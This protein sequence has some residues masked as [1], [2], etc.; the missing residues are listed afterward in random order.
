MTGLVPN[1]LLFDFEIPIRHRSEPP[2]LGGDLD[3]WDERSLLPDLCR[4]E[5]QRPFGRV[6][7]AWSAEG[8]YVA[9]AVSGKQRTLRCDPAEFWKS[10]HLRLCVDFRDA[11]NL[12]RA[13]RFCQQFYL[14][15]TGGGSRRNRPV[16]G[17]HPIQRARED[18]PPVP[19]GRIPIGARVRSDGYALEA[20]LPADCLSGFDP[21]E[22]PRI[23]FYYMF[24]DRE[25]G[26]QCLT[27]GDD[28]YW[29]VDPST[30]ATAVLTA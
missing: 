23:G 7:A 17:S 29:Y 6:Y 28:L 16:A 25:F 14:L 12:K 22:H 19:A 3:D 24:E 15:P 18:A 9:A 5:G 10:D 13:T 27:V 11:R 4:V 1:R 26:Q 21:D 8:L 30:W 2:S 20:H